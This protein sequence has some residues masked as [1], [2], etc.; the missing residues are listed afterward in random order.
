[1]KTGEAQWMLVP[2]YRCDICKKLHRVLPEFVVEYRQYSRDVIE[3]AISG[4][5]VDGPCD[6]TV[7]RWNSHLLQLL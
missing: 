6:M 7:K 4:H 2:R 5:D 3:D 1:M